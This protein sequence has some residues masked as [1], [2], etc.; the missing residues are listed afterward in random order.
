[1]LRSFDFSFSM[2]NLKKV[3]L[4]TNSK[5]S[6]VQKN[7]VRCLDDLGVNGAVTPLGEG[8][9]GFKILLKSSDEKQIKTEILQINDHLCT[10][11]YTHP[12]VKYPIVFENSLDIKGI[13]SHYNFIFNDIQE[14]M[15][16]KSVK[17]RKYFTLKS[18]VKSCITAT[19]WAFKLIKNQI[20]ERDE[21]KRRAEISR[22]G[23]DSRHKSCIET[24]SKKYTL[25]EL[26][27]AEISAKNQI[28]HKRTAPVFFRIIILAV[29][30]YLLPYIGINM[31]TLF[32]SLEKM[33][34]FIPSTFLVLKVE[35]EIFKR[36]EYWNTLSINYEETCLFIIQEAIKKKKLIC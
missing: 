7:I 36:F 27:D 6:R 28:S 14:I 33:L 12:F 22:D 20:F 26:E 11:E 19:P 34:L 1:M 18:L 35:D 10:D 3:L 23:K 8:I 29:Y 30:L 25:E 13:K 21:L 32:T 2:I 4:K 9:A 16:P 5:N 17:K 15:F 24:L 31:T